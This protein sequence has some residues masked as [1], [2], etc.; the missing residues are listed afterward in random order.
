[1]TRRRLDIVIPVLNEEL[2]LPRTIPRLVGF[3]RQHLT[4]YEVRILILDNGSTDR[5]QEVALRLCEAHPRVHFSSIP[6]RGRGGALRAAWL[7]SDADILSY[8]DVDLSADLEAF[9]KLLALVE[10]GYVVATG[11]RHLPESVVERSYQRDFVSRG[12]NVVVKLLFQTRF[13]DAQCGFKAITREAAQVLVP[14]VQDNGWFFDTELLILAEKLGWPIGEVGLHW[15]EDLDSRVHVLSTATSDLVGL[16][17]LKLGG[18]RR[19][20]RRARAAV[21]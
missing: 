21:G 2:A 11:S 15:V 14:L 12:Y 7:A 13:S 19:A 6:E 5:T 4:D 1:V 17:R 8:M 20:V 16:S 10:R 18:L 3:T 9:P